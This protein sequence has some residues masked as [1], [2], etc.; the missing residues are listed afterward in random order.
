MS[1][2]VSRAAAVAAACCVLGALPVTA[3]TRAP[4][5]LVIVIDTLRADRLGAYGNRRGLTPF[6]D[7][8]ARKGTVFV[9]AYA[10]SSWTCPAVASLFT[11]R[12]ASQHHVIA[13]D[14]KLADEEVT[15][16]E[17]L[18][19][20]GYAGAG[21]S[22]NFHIAKSHGYAQ[23]FRHWR[24]YMG[25]A[26]ETKVRGTV[27]RRDGGAWVNSMVAVSPQTP[28]FVYLQ[29][30][31]PHTP[32]DPTAQYRRQFTRSHEGVDE[33]A[34]MSNLTSTLRG[35][36]RLPPNEI[37][38]LSSL[39]DGEVASV[40]AELRTLFADL[41]KT[42]FLDNAVIV[43]TADH[44]EEFGEHGEMGHGK[45]L[46]NTALRVPLIVLAPK[47]EAGGV[48]Q[49]DVSLVDVAP[50][51]LELAG[52]PAV[53]TFEGRSLVPWMTE[54]AAR[55]PHGD[56]LSELEPLSDPDLRAHSRALVSG[57]RKLL[58]NRNGYA[59]SYDIGQ[60]P[61]E[62]RARFVPSGGGPDADLVQSLDR[63]QAELRRDAV[64]AQLKRPLDEATKEKLRALGYQP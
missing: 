20:R 28:L 23:G 52:A 3:Q 50:T 25:T 14:S 12:F 27:L 64:V 29:Y 21:F 24:V 35:T 61:G 6:M 53:P 2:R 10:P 47:T 13:F 37:D 55:P 7:E 36:K 62:L 33:T 46:Y 16:G 42:G 41:Q 56:V 39:Y 51:V 34:A 5:V 4:N 59:V 49:E 45:T 48:V 38:L 44:G 18:A 43:I 1:H 60:D 63:L 30:M 26:G 22:A 15:L 58:I 57:S 11:S 40:D 32:Y 9:N 54:G 19:A 31:E 8:L 17:A